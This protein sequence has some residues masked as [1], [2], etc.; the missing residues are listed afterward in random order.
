[1]KLLGYILP[2]S[3]MGGLACLSI[4]YLSLYPSIRLLLYE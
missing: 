1:M 4:L 2:G 3:V